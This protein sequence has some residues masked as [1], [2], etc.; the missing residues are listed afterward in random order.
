M[1]ARHAPH[2]LRVVADLQ[3]LLA[4]EALAAAGL[5]GLGVVRD[6]HG[7]DIEVVVARGGE[8]ADVVVHRRE[9]ARAAAHAGHAAVPD[10]LVDH[11]QAPLEH[12]E[13]LRRV[14]PRAEQVERAVARQL[15]Q[16]RLGPAFRP[17]QVGLARQ[18]VGV[19]AI[20]L[21]QPVRR[22]GDDEVHA[23]VGQAAD[24]CDAVLVEDA[25]DGALGHCVR[26][27]CP[28]VR[29]RYACPCRRGRTG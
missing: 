25:V 11:R 23:A 4:L 5:L 9:L 19:V 3:P 24:T 10:D 20:V 7:V 29:R 8:E 6:A 14:L 22:I 28:R 2:I 21:A 27:R 18:L 12:H 15:R 13:Q 26:D 16:H 17:G 1:Q